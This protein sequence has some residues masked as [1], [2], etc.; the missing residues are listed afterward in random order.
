MAGTLCKLRNEAYLLILLHASLPSLP[1]QETHQLNKCSAEL[2]RKARSYT[3]LTGIVMRSKLICLP[4]KQSALIEQQLQHVKQAAH[5][6]CS[7]CNADPSL[8]YIVNDIGR[9]LQLQL[10]QG[11]NRGVR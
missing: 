10:G 5:T 3:G 2:H 8:L 1:P 7:N 6:S 11:T 9:Y 4:S